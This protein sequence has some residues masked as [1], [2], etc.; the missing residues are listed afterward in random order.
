MAG[1]G[2][3]EAGLRREKAQKMGYMEEGKGRID[4][5]ELNLNV[6]AETKSIAD[7]NA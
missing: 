6:V 3:P 1:E 7:V 2:N 5:I 4:V